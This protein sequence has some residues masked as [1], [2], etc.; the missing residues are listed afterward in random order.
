MHLTV[1][2]IMDSKCRHFSIFWTMIDRLDFFVTIICVVFCSISVYVY[3]YLYVC[4]CVVVIYIVR[5]CVS[6]GR[7][8]RLSQLFRGNYK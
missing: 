2:G 5:M 3:V 1:M 7:E 6:S 8:E 4:M